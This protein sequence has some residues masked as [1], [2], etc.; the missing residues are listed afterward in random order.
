MTNHYRSLISLPSYIF[1]L[2]ACASADFTALEE[3][4]NF[5]ELR[6]FSYYAC[7][8]SSKSQQQQTQPAWVYQHTAQAYLKNSSH[9][10]RIFYHL[11]KQAQQQGVLMAKG[12]QDCKDWVYAKQFKQYVYHLIN[13]KKIIH[14]S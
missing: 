7:L 8:S 3:N 5:D 10:S 14:S 1:L 11:Q 13:H 4:W 6:Y 2:H 9:S 12:K